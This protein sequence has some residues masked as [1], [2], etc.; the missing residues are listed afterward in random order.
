MQ[1]SKRTFGI[2]IIIISLLGLGAW[3]YFLFIK[4]TPPTIIDTAVD[5]DSFAPKIGLNP[6]IKPPATLK[7]DEEEVVTPPLV[8]TLEVF[9]LKQLV[10]TPISG[11]I[12]IAKT[13]PKILPLVDQNA[14]NSSDATKSSTPEEKKMP[15]FSPKTKLAVPKQEIEN[16]TA[17]R[18]ADKA[19][20]HVFEFALDKNDPAKLISGTD[21]P[22][23]REAFFGDKGDTLIMR[24]LK[25][26]NQTIETFVGAL[27]K[28]IIGGDA[29]PQAKGQFLDQN[30]FDISIA[31]DTSKIFYLELFGE[32]IIGVTSTPTGERRT[33]VFDSLFHG[34]TSQWV[35]LKFVGISTKPSGLVPGFS[36]ILDLGTKKMKRVIGNINGLIS[37]FSPSVSLVAYSDNNASLKIYNIKSG[38]YIN[39]G[40]RTFADKCIWTKDDLVLYCAIPQSLQ[41]ALY[42]DTWYDGSISLTDGI[43]KFDS[44]TGISSFLHNLTGSESGIDGIRLSLNYEENYLFF[45]NKKDSSLWSL[46]LR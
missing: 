13:R 23:S 25:N 44:K 17:I 41:T 8:E 42:P 36:Y 38:S 12:A 32:K 27:P 3:I 4:T 19:T 26:D 30:I 37:N 2:V 28:D 45:I 7:P 34:W 15:I 11:F 10:K 31:G 33:Q 43:W 16:Y 1:I 20:G 22:R 6:S 24:Y 39:T 18:Y 46:K 5:N 21:I 9:I 29:L 35:N 40:A 14:P